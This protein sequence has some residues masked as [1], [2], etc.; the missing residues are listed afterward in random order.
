M[1]STAAVMRRARLSCWYS[2]SGYDVSKAKASVP[3][4]SNKLAE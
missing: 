1:L 4:A 2:R 3:V